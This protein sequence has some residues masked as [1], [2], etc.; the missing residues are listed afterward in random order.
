MLQM[1]QQRRQEEMKSKLVDARAKYDELLAQGKKEFSAVSEKLKAIL[2]R[3]ARA[4]LQNKKLTKTDAEKFYISS[5][6]LIHAVRKHLND[7]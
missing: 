1:E 5:K 4:L 2:H 3:T 6:Y 7:V